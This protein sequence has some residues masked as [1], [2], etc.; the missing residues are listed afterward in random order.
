MPVILKSNE[1]SAHEKIEL[2]RDQSSYLRR[3]FT[4]CQKTACFA[5]LFFG[6]VP[7]FFLYY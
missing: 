3:N 5:M 4:Y 2:L 7:H 6:S 1:V